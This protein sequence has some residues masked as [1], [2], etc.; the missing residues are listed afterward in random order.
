[1]HDAAELGACDNEGFGENEKTFITLTDIGKSDD[2]I[3]QL[4]AELESFTSNSSLAWAQPHADY[5]NV[6]QRTSFLGDEMDMTYC[7]FVKDKL[8]ANSSHPQDMNIPITL[9]YN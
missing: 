9:V 1:M 8:L 5:Q 3:T 6:N 4:W 2:N 7:H